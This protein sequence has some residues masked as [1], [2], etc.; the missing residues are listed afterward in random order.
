MSESKWWS[1]YGDFEP[2]DD[3][4][5]HAG[6]VVAY[7]RKKRGFT[8]KG[9]AIALGKDERTV[10]MIEAGM[11]IDSLERRQVL[12]KLLRI[13]PV[14]LALDAHFFD[15]NGSVTQEI[16]RIEVE[17]DTY[18]LYCQL[19]PLIWKQQ[20]YTP[21]VTSQID[22]H[23]SKLKAIV[24]ERPNSE[25]ERWQSLLCKY[26]QLATR[27]K[28]HTMQ[29][30][31]ALQYAHLAVDLAM[32]MEDVELIANSLFRRAR[33]Y[34]EHSSLTTDPYQ[35]HRY[36][37]LAQVDTEGALNRIE[38]TGETD[39]LKGNIYL[40]AAEVN[41]LF[42]SND[43]KLRSQ[44]LDWQAKVG[45]IL[46]RGPLEDDGSLTKL[47]KTA[48]HH[49][50]AK[51]HLQFGHIREARDAINRTWKILSPSQTS[52]RTYIYLTEAKI[53]MVEKE[54][55]GSARC[56]I[57]AHA[58]AAIRR[59]QKQQE[60]IKQIYKRMVELDENNPYVCRLGVELNMF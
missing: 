37:R 52:L 4:Y 14:L 58:M 49:E 17:N 26:Y 57:E 32:E 54:L 51:V 10:Q 28:Q 13:P 34:M 27:I 8:Q 35:Q 41:S 3:G 59:S 24:R 5:P 46:Y 19:L 1:S 48:L 44:C 9:L 43:R 56:G 38:H 30:D 45:N 39:S 12:A 20:S 22:N 21:A 18:E 25:K 40:I 42:A 11:N 15:T 29:Q 50:Q 31:Q 23:L 16:S 33:M 36:W 60:E 47:N 53:F 2:G 7:Y 6:Q 55:E